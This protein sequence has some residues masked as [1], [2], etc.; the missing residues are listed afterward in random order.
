VAR[1]AALRKA[2]AR[3]CAGTWTRKLH[4][5]FGG[6]NAHIRVCTDDHDCCVG[7]KR[8]NKGRKSAVA[9]VHGQRLAL[10]AAARQLELLDDVGDLLEAV[11]IVV[12]LA[13]A[14]R[15]DEKRHALEQNNLAGI[16]LKCQLPEGTKKTFRRE[17]VLEHIVAGVVLRTGC[18]C[19]GITSSA[20]HVL[21][22]SSS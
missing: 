6:G 2:S 22:K 18:G 1:W 4:V 13:A 15:N 19:D 9:D 3:A 21:A 17:R 5:H 16:A 11:H 20:A 10:T 7:G 8:A 14:L 12:L